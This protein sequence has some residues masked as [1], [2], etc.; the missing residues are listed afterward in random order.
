MSRYFLTNEWITKMESRLNDPNFEYRTAIAL[1]A[2]WVVLYLSKRGRPFRVENLG[3]GVKLITTKVD[4][5]P[6]YHGTGRI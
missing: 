5:C 6:K 4:I 3:A 1:A 2:Q